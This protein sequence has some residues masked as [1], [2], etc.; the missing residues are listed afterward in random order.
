V[1]GKKGAGAGGAKPPKRKSQRASST[2][3]PTCR[4]AASEVFRALAIYSGR[5]CLGHLLPRGP[6]GFEAY[7]CND[8]S[9]GIFP[10][11]KSAADAISEAAL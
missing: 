2:Q 5:E 11:Q 1:K 9:L 4:L 6:L 10:N 7:D 3:S 8:K